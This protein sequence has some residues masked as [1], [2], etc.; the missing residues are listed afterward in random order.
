M[1]ALTYV[2]YNRPSFM[3]REA[4]V[5]Y[6]VERILAT[7]SLLPGEETSMK[8]AFQLL[9]GEMPRPIVSCHRH[10]YHLGARSL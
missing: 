10:A 4:L 8:V 5:T 9:S 7:E 6:K 3:I 2:S 1:K